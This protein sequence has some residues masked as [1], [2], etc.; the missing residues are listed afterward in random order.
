MGRLGEW[1]LRQA[2]QQMKAWLDEGLPRLLLSVNLSSCQLKEGGVASVVASVLAE[3]GLDPRLLQIEL[4]ESGVIAQD[5]ATVTQLQRLKG[6]GVT[7]AIDDFGTG[8]SALGYLRHFPVDVIKIDRSFVGAISASSVDADFVAAVIAMARR[9][10]LTVV[11]EGVETDE[12]LAFLNDNACDQ[13]QGFLFSEPL[14]ADRFKEMALARAAGA[15]R[16]SGAR[17]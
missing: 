13:A 8:Y 7:L 3:T 11:A 16:L 1:V 4:T 10:N 6:L 15:S 14:P 17:S 5:S 2:C 12:Q 9:L